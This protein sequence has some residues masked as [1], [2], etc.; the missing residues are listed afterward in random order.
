M[1]DP[2]AD[3]SYSRRPLPLVGRAVIGTLRR[4][5]KKIAEISLRD[6]RIR[7]DRDTLLLMSQLLV[8]DTMR[9]LRVRAEAATSVLFI[10]LMV[11]LEPHHVAVTLEGED[12]CGDAV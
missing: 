4:L 10:V 9:C 3:R 8:L 11:T 12:V 6:F 5:Q 1:G 2:R 7:I